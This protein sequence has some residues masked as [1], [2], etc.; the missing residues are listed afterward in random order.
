MNDFKPITFE[1]LP[2]AVN[3]LLQEV[4]AIKNH[5]FNSSSTNMIQVQ[6]KPEKEFLT[7][8]DVCSILDMKKSGIYNLIYQNKIPYFKRGG[9]VYFDAKE[10]DQWVR[11]DR[12][13]TL[14][15]LQE[16]ANQEL[17]K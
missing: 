6:S 14:K 2:E 3:Q 12:R 9:R 13:K 17:R 7:V 15:Q 5:L 16:E 10:I 11:S 8:L 4:Y 1:Q